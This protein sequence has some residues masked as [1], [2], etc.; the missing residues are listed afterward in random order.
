MRQPSFAPAL[1]AASCLA[2][3]L[4]ATALP[5]QEGIVV[6]PPPLAVTPSPGS[7]PEPP[8]HLRGTTPSFEDQ[9]ME[10]V[11]VERLANGQLAPLKRV[12]L[13]DNSA[14]LHSSNMATRNF[15]MHCDP[16]TNTLPGDR[17]TTA[18]YSWNGAAENIAAGFT[19]P[20]AVMAGWMASSGHRANILSTGMR[21]LGIGYVLQSGDQANVR[22]SAT[23]LCPSTTSNNGPY[24]HYWTQNFGIRN[25]VYPVVI[26]REAFQA[27]GPLV[28]LYLYGA[29][30]AQE[31]RLQNESGTFTAWQP[32]ATNVAWQLSAGDGTKTVNVELRNGATVRTTSDTIVLVDT[33]NFIFADGFESGNTSA[34]SQTV[35]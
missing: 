32:F 26:N 30:W 5:A 27:S 1:L 28:D 31:M 25:V 17:M 22:Q 13:L 8:P 20:A 33:A 14:E 4:C 3:L 35:P 10:L 29:G 7:Q 23:G 6:M 15:H 9:V 16:D 18:G 24:Q 34:W 11:N 12:D 19:T 21:E 2:A